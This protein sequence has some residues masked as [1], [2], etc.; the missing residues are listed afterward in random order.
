[1]QKSINSEI[2]Q[3]GLHLINMNF[4]TFHKQ[5]FK[6]GC[7]NIHQIYAWQPNFE[8]TNLT[9]WIKRSLLIK[10]R[11]GFYTFPEYLTKNDFAY[12]ISNQIYAPSYI[13]MHTVLAFYDIIP[14]AVT[15]ITA[16]TTLKTSNFKNK[17][18]DFSYNTVRSNLFFGYEPKFWQDE[19]VFMI[20]TPEKALLDLLYLYPF[21]ATEEA[22]EELRLDEEFLHSSFNV[23]HFRKYLEQFQSPALDKRAKL[24][25]KVYDL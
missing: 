24:F 4:L 1:M 25:L 8:K 12:Y 16:V 13:S 6:Q 15:S 2:N 22:L 9:R 3:R 5:F 21:Y 20:A 19:R 11:N 10:L 14:E 17:F 7:I 23:E 18:G